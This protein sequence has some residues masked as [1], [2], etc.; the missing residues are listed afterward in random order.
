M[1]LLILDKVTG[2]HVS[3]AD[4][5]KLEDVVLSRKCIK[6]GVQAIQQGCDLSRVQ[7]S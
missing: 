4:C 7:F 6:L 3:V 5:F 1:V 2:T